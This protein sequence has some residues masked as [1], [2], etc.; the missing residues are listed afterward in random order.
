[1]SELADRL[2]EFLSGT[3]PLDGVFFDDHHPIHKGKFWWRQ[4]LPALRETIAALRSEPE[5]SELA[6]TPTGEAADAFWRYW[7]ANGET[8]KHGY[9]ESTWGAINAALRVAGVRKHVYAAPSRETDQR[10]NSNPAPMHGQSKTG[11]TGSHPDAPTNQRSEAETKEQSAGVVHQP[12]HKGEPTSVQSSDHPTAEPALSAEQNYKSVWKPDEL[13]RIIDQYVKHY[14]LNDGETCYDPSDEERIV[15]KDAIMGLLVDREWDAEWGKH[16]AS[17]AAL[18]SLTARD[19]FAKENAALS[20]QWLDW[21]VK[22]RD[23]GIEAAAKALAAMPVRE[24]RLGGQATKYIQR[25][26]AINTVRA[27]KGAGH[28]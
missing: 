21:G 18:S 5:G 10:E 16:I 22:R 4:Y 7:K 12:K 8:H 15:I 23:E 1:M 20:Q 25:D 19:E 9:Y 6:I 14:E 27:L 2:I 11:L 28:D 13:E 3:A 24:E 26:E 17:L